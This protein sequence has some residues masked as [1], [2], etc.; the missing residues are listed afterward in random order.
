MKR[1]LLLLCFL[2]T[3]LFAV[4]R[5]IDGDPLSA[6]DKASLNRNFRDIDIRF[7]NTVKKDANG[8]KVG[9]FT[10]LAFPNTGD[11]AVTGVGF[12]PRLIILYSA[13]D[14]A[15]MVFGACTDSGQFSG[16]IFEG[17]ASA[18]SASKCFEYTGNAPNAVLKSMD[19]DGFTL[20]FSGTNATFDS[21]TIGYIAFQ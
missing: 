3:Q 9:T 5:T 18:M 7:L 16:G 8:I 19:S 12:K 4:S 14:N 20:T 17:T 2:P 21:E 6:K 13:A 1:L 15:R 10:S 11:L